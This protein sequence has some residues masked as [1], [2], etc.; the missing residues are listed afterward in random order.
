[1]TLLVFVSAVA[2]ILLARVYRK[3]FLFQAV[4]EVIAD[5]DDPDPLTSSARARS[6]ARSAIE[7]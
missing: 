7:S 5:D 6:L 1:M 4:L 2:V 3:L